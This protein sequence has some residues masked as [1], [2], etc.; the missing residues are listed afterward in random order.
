M[1]NNHPA[2]NHEEI[3]IIFLSLGSNI[4]PG[5]N[6]PRAVELLKQRLVIEAASGAWQ[7]PDAGGRGPDFVNMA[8]RART[9][10]KPKTLKR[11]I[12]RPI[13]ADLGRVR[14]S[15]KYAPRPID[16]DLMVIDDLVVDPQLWKLAFLAL[17]VAQL[18]PDLQNR[19]TGA[20][21]AEVSARLA[22]RSVLIPRPEVTERIQKI[23][24]S[25]PTHLLEDQV[26]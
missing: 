25:P 5:E 13:E 6:L 24:E 17:P 21:L 16:I 20:S 12:F 18:Y 7:T 26:A 14:T 9:N 3:N 15:D 19:L 23:L 8:L 10:L 2:E 11:Q 1:R 22:Q 4:D